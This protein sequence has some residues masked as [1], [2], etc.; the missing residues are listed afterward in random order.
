MGGEGSM[1]HANQ[2]LKYNRGQLGKRSFKDLKEL[3]RSGSGKTMIEFEKIDPVELGKIK[4]RIREKA[5]KEK[6][7]EI[8]IF[9][10]S[11]LI[12]ATIIFLIFS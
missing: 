9:I 10:I 8:L 12:T 11:F 6:R 3:M 5:Q 2:S 4:A 1:S 7:K